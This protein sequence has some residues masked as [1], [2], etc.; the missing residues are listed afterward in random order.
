MHGAGSES[1]GRQGERDHFQFRD[2]RIGS[3]LERG[4]SGGQAKR[5]NIGIALVTNPRVLF[6]D[7]PTSGLDSY[8]S[9]EVRGGGSAPSRG[10]VVAAG[11]ASLR[12]VRSM[13]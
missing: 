5:V 1:H 12:A 8:T 2:T 9:N 7:E 10:W 4:I 3:V 13:F 6:L 11:F